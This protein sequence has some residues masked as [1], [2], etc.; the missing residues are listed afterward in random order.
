MV[1]KMA[2]KKKLK[3]VGE[4]S[5]VKELREQFLIFN[6]CGK[7]INDWKNFPKNFRRKKH[8]RK[9]KNGARSAA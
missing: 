6:E 1:Q 9:Q 5:K 2:G 3:N 8:L 7:K 4:T